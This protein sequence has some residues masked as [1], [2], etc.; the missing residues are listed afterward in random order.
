M[1]NREI[2]CIFNSSHD[3]HCRRRVQDLKAAGYRVTVYCHVRNGQR[4]KDE[5]D[6]PLHF[7][8]D[9]TSERY[10]Q[11]LMIYR[12]EIR[13]ILRTHGRDALYY[14]YGLDLALVF[15]LVAPRV[16]Y[17]YEEADL[18]HLEAGLQRY[19]VLPKILE[20]LDKQIIR[21]ASLAIFTSE[22]FLRYHFANKR[23]A[24]T[25]LALNKA[26][27]RLIGAS[28]NDQ[29]PTTIDHLAISFIGFIRYRTVYRFA[30]VVGKHFPQHTF[31]F[32][33]PMNP[34]FEPL[35][36]Y[37]NIR[38]HGAYTNRDDLPRIYAATDLAVATYDAAQPNVRLLD[39]N[40]LYEALVMQTPIVVSAGTFLA[41]RV[42]DYGI[43]FAVDASSEE[44]IT[45]FLRSLTTEALDACRARARELPA[46]EAVEDNHELITRL[47]EL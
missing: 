11:R 19:R 21:R 28:T 13:D 35:R 9:L 43:G 7:L 32:Y 8:A 33:G 15:R 30:E 12:R 1:V 40:K 2:I 27:R 39:P 37:P 23:P 34:D 3:S 4:G 29:R 44:A 24:N 26:D 46:T 42:R 25:C 6:Y 10:R 18:M 45:A 5:A 20:C 31:H 36:E 38:F 16:R 47:Q 41:E 17:I 14:L 22:G